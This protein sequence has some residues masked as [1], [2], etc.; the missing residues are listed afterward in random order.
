[1]K[2]VFKYP[3]ESFC[4]FKKPDFLEKSGFSAD[5]VQHVLKNRIFWKNPVFPQT[6]F[7]MFSADV[8]QHVLKNR[9]FWKKSGFSGHFDIPAPC[10]PFSPNIVRMGRVF[11]PSRMRMQHRPVRR[12]QPRSSGGT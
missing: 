10:S 6:L 8:V 4:V 11:S 3:S 5:V 7:S 1:M 9:I 2:E 12:D